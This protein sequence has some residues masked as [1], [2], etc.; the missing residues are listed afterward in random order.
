MGLRQSR[1][2]I[3]IT[4]IGDDHRR[5]G[6]GDQQVG[7]GDAHIGLHELVAQYGARLV[8][9]LGDGV[10]RAVELIFLMMRLEQLGDLLAALV[11]G[12][13]DDVTGR[14][15]RQLNN[16]FA[17]VGFNR[18]KTRLLQCLVQRHLL[19]HHGLAL[20]NTA[21]LLLLADRD[22]DL[23]RLLR[24]TGPMH[25]T[26]P[27]QHPLFEIAQVIGQPGKGMLLDL[28]GLGAQ[29]FKLR[30]GIEGLFALIDKAMFGMPQCLL[31]R[32]IRQRLH[33][34]SLECMGF[35]LHVLFF[36]PGAIRH[37]RCPA[38][39][40]CPRATRQCGRCGSVCS[41]VSDGRRY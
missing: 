19:G 25:H 14:L 15:A 20:G 18:L 30:Q 10:E 27:L 24:G 17:K 3:P 26:A 8:D 12:R 5:T 11:H 2:E 22:D 32:G 13:G 41:D 6:L 34:L 38:H 33:R 31:Q 36:T 1:G 35:W 39:R 28:M 29:P 4:F 37:H 9:D 21:R 40:S 23:L 16:V 7:A